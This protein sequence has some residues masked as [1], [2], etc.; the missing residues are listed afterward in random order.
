MRGEKVVRADGASEEV[1]HEKTIGQKLKE[2]WKEF[3]D[4]LD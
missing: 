4:K 3:K 2:S 1:E